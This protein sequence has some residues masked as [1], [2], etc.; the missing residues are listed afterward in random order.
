M[1][2]GVPLS[3]RA[4]SIRIESTPG[5][6]S[7]VH[8]LERLWKIAEDS[9]IAGVTLV[10]KSEPAASYAHAEELAD[11]F[12][13]LKAH[14]KKVICSFE[15]A[16]PKALFACASASRVVINPAGGL[17]YSGI[18]TTHLY[19]EIGRAHV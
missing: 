17:R 19:L 8:L 10:I 6:R 5:T 14:G 18:K 15:D 4:V 9:E 12:R 1:N 11:A 7:H 13:V 16:G 3:E 2:P